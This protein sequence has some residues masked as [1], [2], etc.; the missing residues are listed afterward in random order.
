MR[1]NDKGEIIL[2]RRKAA[3][4][5]LVLSNAMYKL[6]G[7]IRSMAEAYW[8]EFEDV[9]GLNPNKEITYHEGEANK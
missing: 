2:T 5:F 1:K 6:N 4:I 8:K 7:K 3:E 9:L